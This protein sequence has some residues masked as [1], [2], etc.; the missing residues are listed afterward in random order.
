[1]SSESVVRRFL[2]EMWAK[3]NTDLIDVV[4]HEDY[5]ADGRVVGREFVRRNMRRFRT[6]FPDH[7]VRILMLVAS[8]DD[9]AVLFELTGTHQGTFGGIEP[10]GKQM[11]FLES[12]FFKVADGQVISGDFVSDGWDF[13]S[14]WVSCQR[15]SGRTLCDDQPHAFP[16]CV[17]RV[18]PDLS[19]GTARY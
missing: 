18:A 10:T 2:E 19:R 1:M 13:A 17:Q 9:V 7:S 8:G 5:A 11:S 14:S 3:G 12:G 6:G 4:V 16:H 15:T